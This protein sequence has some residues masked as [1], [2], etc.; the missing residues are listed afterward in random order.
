MGKNTRNGSGSTVKTVGSIEGLMEMFQKQIDESRANGFEAD[1]FCTCD[2]CS[3]MREKGEGKSADGRA[4]IGILDFSRK[5]EEEYLLVRTPEG[6]QELSQQV[7][8]IMTERC[9][10]NA[11]WGEQNHNPAIWLAILTEEVGEVAQEVLRTK[12]SK[13]PDIFDYRKEMVQVAA[14]ALAAIECF[15][16]DIVKG[17]QTVSDKIKADEAKKQS[18]A[19]NASEAKHEAAEA[20]AVDGEKV[21]DADAGETLR[22]VR[23]EIMSSIRR[24]Y[25]RKVFGGTIS[26]TE[27]S[28]P[29]LKA[30]IDSLGETLVT[31]LLQARKDAEVPSSRSK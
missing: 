28:D 5:P 8:D 19:F 9:V 15:D 25:G 26:L 11:K 2:L 3:A 12:F 10:Q 27:D 16:R 30:A 13:K 22:S 6:D 7:V 20:K 24:S 23:D 21:S 1:E 14:V 4:N 29:Q 18:D 31:F 17:K